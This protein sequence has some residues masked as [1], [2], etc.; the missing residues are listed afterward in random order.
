MIGRGLRAALSLL[1]LALAVL[2][3][4]AALALAECAVP[5]ELMSLDAKFPQLAQKLRSGGPVRIVALGGASTLGS[6]AGSPDLA[7]PKRL[8]EALRR[9]YPTTPISVVNKGVPRQTAQQMLA[10][11]PSDV[12]AEDPVLV[13][14]ETGTTDAVRGVGVS[15]F[16][17]TLQTGI[18]E[19]KARE[20]D[21]ILI[22]MQYSHST[23]TM[24]DFE[25]YL[26][27]MHR[28]GDVNELYVFPRFE[29]M[30]YWSEQDVFNLDGVSKEERA[31]L[32]ASVYDCLGRNLAAAIRTALQ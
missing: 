23:A 24:I 19:L 14:W 5:A 10:R 9:W 6:A 30:R 32:A 29:M 18:D 17:A 13:L 25:R 20:M 12:F 1:A 2:Q 8:Q 28:S 26:K 22:D 31:G 16:A 3:A 7:Y 27:A 15:E 4:P 21:I 11:F